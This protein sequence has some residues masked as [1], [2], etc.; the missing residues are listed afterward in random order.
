M[1]IGM[2]IV[3]ERR[4]SCKSPRAT[5]WCALADT[6][7][8]NRAIGLG[9]LKL[10]PNDD[11]S[12]AR[13]LVETISGGFP[14]EYEER[15]FEWREHERFTVRRVLRKGLL[16]SMQNEFLLDSRDDGGTEI[17]VR[18][19]LEPKYGVL[20]PIVRLSAR[21]L[22]ARMIDELE[23]VDAEIQA[24]NVACFRVSRSP[25]DELMLDRAARALYERAGGP[26]RDIAERL[27]DFV[28]TAGDPDVAR[29]RPFELAERFQ[30]AP[31]ETLAVCL[32]A[33]QAGVLELSWDLICPSC[34]TAS[35]RSASLAELPAGG[36]CQ[37]CDLSYEIELDQAVEATFQPAPALRRVD[38]GP[39]CIGGPMRTPHV[40][41]QV[42]LPP[43]AEL[44][45]L[46]PREPGRYR[47]FVRGGKT[48]PLEVTEEGRDGAEI[49][50]GE[51]GIEAER[52]ELR[53]DAR[54]VVR[55]LPA[56]ESHL[57]IERLEWASRAATAHAV[58]TLPEFRRQFS[59]DLLRA[60]VTLRVA[61]VALLFTD[62]T[63]STALYSRVGDAKAFKVVHGHF[64]LLSEIVAARHGTVVKT[65]GDAVMA[66]FVEERDALG[67]A[68]DI[69]R[70]FPAFRAEHA[71]AS[72]SFLKVG[73]YAGP[74]YVVTAN[75]ILDYFGQ[76]VNTTARLQS[77]A[78]RGEIV[79]TDDLAA[80]A[81]ARGWL[82]GYAVSERFEAAL[83]GLERPIRAAKILVDTGK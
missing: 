74:C 3:V 59:S 52:L 12:A 13:Y 20:A 67:A 45:L 46:A 81:E 27:V 73:L 77:A 64:D 66:A 71:E 24:G 39:Y 43:S 18:I 78:G 49:T 70:R 36:H 28:R 58:S 51:A 56:R 6:E 72:Q 11:D 10:T 32:H 2:S 33:V 9:A 37:L 21:R 83:K 8:L 7:R 47:L 23:I 55:H 31:R 53:S 29:I 76:T 82:E 42:I 38:P 26:R 34:R 54:L 60:G 61:K 41:S 65:I 57:K 68:L 25:V 50:I 40:V 4:I 75:G 80:E 35:E 16:R 17:C 62:L 48:W 1:L 22:V 30:S 14:L 44:T 19:V 79:L 5:L 69:Q 15:P 63:D